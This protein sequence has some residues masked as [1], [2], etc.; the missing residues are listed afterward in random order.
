[1]IVFA[2]GLA[3]G[4]LAGLVLFAAA[5]ELARWKGRRR[6]YTVMLDLTPAAARGELDWSGFDRAYATCGL[7][8]DLRR[9]LA[10][11]TTTVPRDHE[12]RLA[13][14]RTLWELLEDWR[15]APS[16]TASAG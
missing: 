2:A 6:A 13:D 15:N 16:T 14:G 7:P 5:L 1:M 9:A 12:V 10:N 8:R 4:L 3:C 11:P